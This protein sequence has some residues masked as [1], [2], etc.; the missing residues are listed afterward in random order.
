MGPDI[1]G[2]IDAP[3]GP[4][5]L[6][7]WKEIATILAWTYGGWL[8]C[9]VV[10]RG[11]NARWPLLIEAPLLAACASL[12]LMVSHHGWA[13]AGSSMA[14]LA[15]GAYVGTTFIRRGVAW[16][17]QSEAPDRRMMASDAEH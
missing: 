13:I 5:R 1:G 9:K 15:A 12:F 2:S 4:L 16:D 10:V 11:F 14:V 6:P 3:L 7:A 8:G 17:S